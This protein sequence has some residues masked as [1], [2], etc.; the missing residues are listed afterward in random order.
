[1]THFV[2]IFFSSL[3]MCSNVFAG[4]VSSVSLGSLSSALNERM[5]VMKAVA[6]Y[7]A[8]H[9]LPVEDLPREQVVLDHMLQNAEQAGLEPHSVGPFVHALM[10]AS[11][12]IQYRYRA[13]WL[14]APDSDLPVTDLAETRQQI[15]RLDTQI[16]TAISQRL[17]T[18]TFSQDDIAFLMSQLTASHLS[19][20]D[21]NSLCAALSRIQRLY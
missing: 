14:S 15:E 13:D 1:M 5:Q 9:H 7:K 6:G 16:L 12:A 19:E 3:F 18:G 17:M 4:S 20:N 21:K 11:K 8:L 2:A 10:N